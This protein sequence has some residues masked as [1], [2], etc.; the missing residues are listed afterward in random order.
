MEKK[1]VISKRILIVISFLFFSTCGSMSERE[2]SILDYSD[3]DISK[4]ETFLVKIEQYTTNGVYYHQK[5]YR[6]LL[7]IA[8]TV[9]EG[10]DLSVMKNSIGF[11]YDKKEHSKNKLYLGIEIEIPIDAFFRDSSYV[12][13][14][15]AILK[16]NLSDILFVIYSCKKVFSENEVVG[17]VIGIFW[18]AKNSEE[19]L[20]IWI[21]KRDVLLFEGKRLTINEL[22]E[23]NTITNSECKVIRLPI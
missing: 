10:K 14:A 2:E 12:T 5:Y 1:I 16:R 22:I 7:G 4:Y 3:D 21:D 11:Y 15:T 18:E 9:S 17:M 19:M 23:R 6:Y 13:R 8:K 20:N